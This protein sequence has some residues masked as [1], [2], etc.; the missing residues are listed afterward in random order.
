MV[1]GGPLSLRGIDPLLCE[2]LG[3]L[4]LEIRILELVQYRPQIETLGILGVLS[5]GVRDVSSSVEVLRE[6]HGRRGRDTDLVGLHLHHS[7]V[8]RCGPVLLLRLGL[9]FGDGTGLAAVDLRQDSFSLLLLP[10][11]VLLVVP[12]E[13]QHAELAHKVP[14]GN[15]D[16]VFDLLVPVDEELEGRALDPSYGHEVVTDLSGREGDQPCEDGS[17][18]E[19]HDLPCLCGIGE[20]LVRIGEVRECRLHL[21][22]RQGAELGPPDLCHV[23][24]DGLDG[25][26]TDELSFPVVVGSDD[27]L[28]RIGSEI[29]YGA[30]D[31]LDT[32]RLHLGCEHKVRRVDGAPVVVFLWIIQFYDVTPETDDVVV[33]AS[34]GERYHRGPACALRCGFTVG[35]YG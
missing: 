25:L 18:R 5:T 30:E 12:F 14:I 17:P 10:E 4:G 9:I 34:G 27:D 20:L 31:R 28:V 26:H 11:G 24:I 6:L 3:R 23:G 7:G 35:E 33:V 32:Y 8:E 15:G 16:E 29:L 19:V 13:C 21:S 1:R 2:D 22:F